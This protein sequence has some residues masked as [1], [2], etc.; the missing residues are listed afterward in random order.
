M[1]IVKFMLKMFAVAVLVMVIVTGIAVIYLK[2]FGNAAIGQMVS[3]ALGSDVKFQ[4]IS[5]D[6]V[7]GRV[8]FTGFSVVNKIEFEENIFKADKFIVS[9]DKERFDRDRTLVMEEI[10][11]EKGTITIE[12]N[13]KGI[14]NVASI[15]TEDP[16][17]FESV[18]YAAAMPSGE[19]FFNF[20]KTCRKIRI[21]NSKLRF[22]DHYISREMFYF[23]FDNVDLEFNTTPMPEGNIGASCR[24]DMT[25]PMQ[26]GSNGSVMLR[27]NLAIYTERIDL[28]GSLSTKN[29][30]IVLFS[31]YFNRYT[32]FN[33]NSGTFSSSTDIRIHNNMLDSPTTV[34]FSGL[35]LYIKPGMENSLFLETAVNRLA[36]YLMSRQGD[37]YFDFV[38]KGPVQKPQAGIGP[39][40]KMAIGMVVLEEFNKALQHWQN[41]AQ[42]Y[43]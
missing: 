21:I 27:A 43:Q 9:I 22:I 39:R 20:A 7:K 2:F 33:F 23:Y 28:E 34:I 18:A 38:L 14:F 32:P 37:I 4:N 29:I 1:D 41:V 16:A 6:L 35:N 19:G 13:K 42:S 10:L 17:W 5:F 12:R 31:P 3:K 11:I 26:S 40:V 8:H 15:N 30:N 36:P 24:L 25:I